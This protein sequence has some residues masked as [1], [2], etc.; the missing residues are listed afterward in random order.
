MINVEKKLGQNFA[1]W[2]VENKRTDNENEAKRDRG[3][4]GNFISDP[5]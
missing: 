1:Q 5:I 4:H 2:R 3:E